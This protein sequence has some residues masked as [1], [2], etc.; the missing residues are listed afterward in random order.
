MCDIIW[1]I[2]EGVEKSGK[3]RTS[4]MDGPKAN[5]GFSNSNCCKGRI[6]IFKDEKIEWAIAGRS[7]SK[8]LDVLNAVSVLKSKFKFQH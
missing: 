7:Q 5:T 6:I 8:L 1:L 2:G 3:V 4:F